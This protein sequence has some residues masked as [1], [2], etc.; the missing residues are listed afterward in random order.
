MGKWLTIMVVLLV[1][2]A[3]LAGCKVG[4]SGSGLGEGRGALTQYD[5]D[6]FGRSRAPVDLL[7][8]TAPREGRYRIT[9]AGGAGADALR[10]PV[11]WVMRG[12]VPAEQNAFLNAYDRGRGVIAENSGQA[13]ATVGLRATG[14]DT[15][16]LVFTSRTNDVGAYSFEIEA[17]SRPNP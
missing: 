14:G 12:R 10:N 17:I 8:F 1:A 7:Y 3:L 5:F 16:T 15:F 4:S 9:L 6:P 2:V 11:I 13:I